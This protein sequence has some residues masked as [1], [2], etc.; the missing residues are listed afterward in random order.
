MS[1]LSLDSDM[2]F[3]ITARFIAKGS[4][5]PVTGDPYRVRLFDKDIFDNDFI[6][7]S[8]IDSNGYA[9]IA[10]RHQAF[11]DLANIETFPD[12]Y[13]VVYKNDVPV[14]QSQVMQD[15]DL[16]TIQQYKK[17]EGEVVDLGTYLIDA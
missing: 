1:K 11:G 13:F 15:I 9:K 14:F 16:E 10:F 5:A 7:E 6:G 12:F 3:E 8:G 17:G 2:M 4:D